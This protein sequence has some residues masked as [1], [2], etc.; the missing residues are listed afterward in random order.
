MKTCFNMEDVEGWLDEDTFFRGSPQVEGFGQVVH[1][2][3]AVKVPVSLHGSSGSGFDG[4]VGFMTHDSVQRT[5][6]A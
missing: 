2:D 5:S 6:E 3:A 4:F 1:Y